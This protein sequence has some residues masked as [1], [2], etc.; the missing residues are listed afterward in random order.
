MQTITPKWIAANGLWNW[1]TG[2][3]KY[4]IT[5]GS[6]EHEFRVKVPF[7]QTDRAMGR[8]PMC[9]EVNAWSHSGWELRYEKEFIGAQPSAEN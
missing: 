7:S 2:R 1:F 4:T 8:C 3:K 5:C 9:G 6:C